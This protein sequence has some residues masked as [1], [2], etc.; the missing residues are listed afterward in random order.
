MTGGRVR[1]LIRTAMAEKLVSRAAD[2]GVRFARLSRPDA[3]TLDAW[4]CAADE[5][6]LR[7]MLDGLSIEYRVSDAAGFARRA[8]FLRRR[9]MLLPSLVAAVAVVFMLSTRI[10]TVNV[11]GARDAKAVT[12]AL[13][14]MGVKPGVSK[15]NLDFSALSRRLE[16]IFPEY[17][18]FGVKASGVCLMVDARPADSAPEVYVRENARDLVSDAD[19]VILRVDAAAG[20]ALVKPGDTVRKGDTLILGEERVSASGETERVRA[21]GSVI[22]RLWTEGRAEIPLVREEKAH[23]GRTSE[24]VTLST[25]FFEKRLSGE[26]PFTDYETGREKMAVIGLFLPAY[27]VRETYFERETVYVSENGQMAE[28]A[29]RARAYAAARLEAAPSAAENG[30]FY[31]TN[32]ENGVLTVRCVVEWTKEIAR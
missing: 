13:N 11:T 22:A 30:I 28:N 31:E 14:G 3:R 29:A 32:S 17:A 2:E 21:Q 8:R 10:W 23:T 25:P 6:R 19:G 4:V 12:D 27:L 15:N 1:F 9:F 24:S 26:N 5:K 18:F 7:A 16:A 20:R